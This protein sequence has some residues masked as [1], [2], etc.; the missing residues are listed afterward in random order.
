[1]S[2]NVTATNKVTG[3]VIEL[4]VGNL[5]QLIQAWEVASEYAKTA[6]R[7]KTKLKEIVP[8]YVETNVSEEING[9]QFRVSS[10]Q[11]MNYDKSVLREHLDEDTFDVLMKP[12]KSA[13]DNYIKENLEELGERS[14]A[15]RQAMIPDGKPYEVIKLEKLK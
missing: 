6:D 14:T 13:I 3:E 11:R 12:D 4:E 2:K 9:R 10:V 5:E 1:M 7:L 15:I 8:A